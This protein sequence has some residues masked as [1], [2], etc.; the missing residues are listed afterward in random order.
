MN[1]SLNPLNYTLGQL[2]K[3]LTAAVVAA[4]GLF[5]YAITDGHIDGGEFAGILSL[6]VVTFG[7]AFAVK[8]DTTVTPEP[9]NPATQ[10]ADV[11]ADEHVTSWTDPAPLS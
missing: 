10:W 9:V 1:P 8:N 5:V 11:Y 3:A 2:R 7:G 6:F 4:A